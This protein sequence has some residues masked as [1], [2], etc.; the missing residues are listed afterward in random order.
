MREGPLF[1]FQLFNFQFPIV[2]SELPEVR[3]F[4]TPDCT[5]PSPRP[6]VPLLKTGG[7]LC[8][9][10]CVLWLVYRGLCF[11]RLLA[12]HYDSY[13]LA[14]ELDDHERCYRH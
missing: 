2:G 13:Y 7:E 10:A 14:E 8:Y 4:T 6:I 3:E 5:R 11:V 9:V 1:N 12:D